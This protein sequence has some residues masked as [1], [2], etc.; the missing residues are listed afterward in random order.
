MSRDPAARRG[1]FRLSAAT[2]TDVEARDPAASMAL[3]F[4]AMRHPLD[5]L[6][7]DVARRKAATGGAGRSRLGPTALALGL[8]T[9]LVGIL[10]GCAAGALRTPKKVDSA[11]RAQIVREIEAKQR[12]NDAQAR[13]IAALR[14]Q[15]SAAQ[16]SA[17]ARAS[18]GGLRSQLTQAQA[19]AGLTPASGAGLVVR[20][21]NPTASPGADSADGNPRTGTNAAQLS[22]TDLSRVV[23]GLWQAGAT[24]VAV[25][26]QRLS[27]LSAIRFAGSAVLVNYRPLTT[28][29]VI[30]ALG[31]SALAS[32]F[33]ANDG[34]RY[35][36]TLRSSGFTASSTTSSVDLPA[37]VAA[38]VTHSTPSH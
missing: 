4:D 28:P 37:A 6:Y 30:R 19:A 35:L 3:I 34:G 13:Q 12:A 9:L 21:D 24:A 33:G 27:S 29:Y 1:R 10:I 20:L 26:D 18:K 36:T 17:L 2:T 25:N 14:S 8:V 38:P 5:P 16:S 23:N 32:D 7:E 31:P 11:A 15:V 22:S